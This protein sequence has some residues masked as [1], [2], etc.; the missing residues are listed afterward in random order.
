MQYHSTEACVKKKLHKQK[1]HIPALKY[2][3]FLKSAFPGYTKHIYSTKYITSICTETYLNLVVRAWV[4]KK[5]ESFFEGI[6]TYPF[7]TTT[8]AAALLS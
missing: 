5:G 2:F 1:Q 3:F 8:S 6:Q 7:D 4:E